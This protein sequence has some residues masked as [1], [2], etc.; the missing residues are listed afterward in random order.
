MMKLCAVVC[1][2]FESFYV[3]PHQ[4]QKEMT[5]YIP[6]N[7]RYIVYIERHVR[8]VSL[9]TLLAIIFLYIY[10]SRNVILLHID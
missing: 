8:V 3:L 10:L 6:R 7:D 1:G 5:I 4:F 2:I 9:L